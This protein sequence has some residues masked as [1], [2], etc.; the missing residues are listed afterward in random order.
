MTLGLVYLIVLV[1][2][3]LCGFLGK[4]KPNSK[5]TIVA[6]VVMIAACVYASIEYTWFHILGFVGI[7]LIGLNIFGAI[8][9]IKKSNAEQ[10]AREDKIFNV[11]DDEV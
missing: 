7:T 9:M 4:D 11:D 1:V 8:E 10:K 2:A 6:G 3:V 5:L